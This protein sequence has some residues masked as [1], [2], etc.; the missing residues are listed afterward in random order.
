M[1][2]QSWF[3]DKGS[4]AD[5]VKLY[6]EL[7]SC[8]ANILRSFSKEN[9]VNFLKLKY[10]LKKAS[11]SVQNAIVQNVEKIATEPMKEVKKAS[12]EKEI[13]KRSEELSFKK[14]NMAMYPMELHSTYRQRV[15]DFYL[16]CELKF[17]LNALSGDNEIQALEIIIQLEDLWTRIDRAW[18]ILNHWKEHNRIMPTEESED[19]SK[20]S[21]V[22]LVMMRNKLESR[23]SKRQKTIDAMAIVV[24][25]SPEDKSLLN[26]FNRKLEQL[27]QL[28]IDLETIR[29]ILKNE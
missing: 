8:N 7:P 14:E 19:F 5:G 17:Q 3:S 24:E 27:Q 22:Q 9:A 23:I 10:E 25:N 18:K 15:N 4:F 26:S 11:F 28:K 29:K 16:A 13:I 6:S 21:G 1:D 20:L 2:I 12:L